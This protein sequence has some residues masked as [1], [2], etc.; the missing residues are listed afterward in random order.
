MESGIRSLT[1]VYIV[2]VYLRRIWYSGLRYTEYFRG[3]NYI[4]YL[5]NRLTDRVG[6][7]YGND[8]SSALL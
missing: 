7:Q 3:K 1:Q 6:W 5:A 2:E 4:L 8:G